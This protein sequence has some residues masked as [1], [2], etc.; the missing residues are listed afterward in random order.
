MIFLYNQ[1]IIYINP[2]CIYLYRYINII[3]RATIY[4]K[5]EYFPSEVQT[6]ETKKIAAIVAVIIIIVAAAAAY[7]SLGGSGGNDD[8][9]AHPLILDQVYPSEDNVLNGTYEIQ[10]NLVLVTL[11][12][13]EGNVAA[14]LDWITSDA[15][16][17]ILADEFVPL[18]E[19]QRTTYEAPSESGQTTITLSGSTS[20]TETMLALVEEYMQ[21]YPYMTITVGTGGSGVGEQQ[22]AEGVVDIG[23]L[24]RDLSQ[25]GAD[26]GLIA[27]N[28]GK[29]GVAV[30]ANIDGIGSL[31]LEQVASIFSGEITNW[32]QVGGPD[33]EIAVVIRE[34]GS[35]TREC[36]ENAMDTVDPN[37][38]VKIDATSYNSTGG[39][40]SQVQSLYGSIGYISL[41]QVQNL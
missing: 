16:Q 22:A 10:R 38:T 15:G 33:Q 28:I 34:D 7:V 3:N 11:G 32:S 31:T 6:L 20:L 9:S 8:S 17:E 30:I 1:W 4:T 40:I 13:P 21:K 12:E 14:F 39:V 27:H 24:S 36:F 19:D 41:G 35:G 25:E 5:L 2:Y 29:D 23:M 18:P 37:W 26:N